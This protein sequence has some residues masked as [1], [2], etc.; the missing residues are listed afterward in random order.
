MHIKNLNECILKKLQ[1]FLRSWIICDFFSF[2]LFSFFFSFLFLSETN[3]HGMTY[4]KVP[5][6]LKDRFFYI[7]F[8][9][10][11][12]ACGIL[13]PWS[14]IKPVSPELG[15]QSLNH[16]T[17]REVFFFLT[18]PHCMNTILNKNWSTLIWPAHSFLS[19]QI[20]V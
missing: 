17:T 1:L 16:W 19:S 10:C 4:I 13:V 3:E 11:L 7:Y 18:M 5:K 12:V 2:C 15:A 6:G 9:S 20:W 14:G 8:L